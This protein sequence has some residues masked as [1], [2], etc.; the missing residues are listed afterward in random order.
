M[1]IVKL[2]SM[3]IG[4]GFR[5]STVRGGAMAAPIDPFLGVDHAHMSQPT[6]QPHPHAG[7]SAV[8]YLFSD[9]ETGILNRDSLGIKNLIQPGGLH[10]TAAGSGIVHEEIPAETGK[11]VHMLQIF[12]NLAINKQGAK[13]F[14]LSIDPKDVP[15]VQLAGAT[16][17]VP[18]GTYGT[19]TSPLHPP[20]DV[21]LLDVSLDDGIE[22]SLPVSAGCAAFVMPILGDLIVDGQLFDDNPHSSLPVYA[23]QSSPYEIK[24]RAVNGKAQAV[25][26]SGA[27]L[28]QPVHWKGSLALASPEALVERVVA[29]TRGEFGVL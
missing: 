17:R 14:A 16:V 13:P 29:Y 23:E 19:V 7:F 15:T 11:I 27:P 5:A 6:F 10:W 25:F 22:V 4:E 12:V 26:F 21:S 28:R 3:N 8:S 24:V 1:E 20:T 2:Q 9:S 18:L